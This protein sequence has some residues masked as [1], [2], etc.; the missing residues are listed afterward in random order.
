MRSTRL[1][2]AVMSRNSVRRRTLPSLGA[3]SKLAFALASSSTMCLRKVDVG[4]PLNLFAWGRGLPLRRAYAWAGSQK[5][6]VSFAVHGWTEPQTAFQ[7]S[8][9][10]ASSLD[11]L[12]ASSLDWLY[13]NAARRRLHKRGDDEPRQNAMADFF[14]RSRGDDSELKC[15]YRMIVHNTEAS[16]RYAALRSP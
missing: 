2:L 12:R 16:R 13:P 8:V 10:R 3:A 14:R 4:A 5:N 11:R 7:A 6:I 1:P 9:F 15:R